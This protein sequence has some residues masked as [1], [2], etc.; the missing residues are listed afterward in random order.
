MFLLLVLVLLPCELCPTTKPTC[1]LFAF[2]VTQQHKVAH[3]CKVEGKWHVVFKMFPQ[4][5]PT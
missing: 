3:N 2:Y 5:N 1:I 4:L